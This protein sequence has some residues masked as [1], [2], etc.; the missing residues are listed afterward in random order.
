MRR[1][2]VL[3]LAIMMVGC[4]PS[5][6]L[7]NPK[8]Y[9]SNSVT[10]VSDDDF[11]SQVTVLYRTKKRP[12]SADDREFLI[13]DT[14]PKK[15]ERANEMCQE[16]GM[17]EPVFIEGICYKEDEGFYCTQKFQCKA[18]REEIDKWSSM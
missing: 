10:H 8:L 2:N 3:F 13:K 14:S 15:T 6:S 16:K 12:E 17:S 11:M 1:F 7:V 9:G 5:S 4:S 18:T